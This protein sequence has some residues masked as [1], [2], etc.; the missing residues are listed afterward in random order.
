MKCLNLCLMFLMALGIVKLAN[1]QCQAGETEILFNLVPDNYG[2]ETTWN[3]T[4]PGGGTVYASGGPY[5]NNNTTPINASVCVPTGSQVVFTISDSYGD[6]ICCSSGNGSYT[7]SIS[8]V[9]VASGGSF[10]NSESMTFFAPLLSY[11]IMMGKVQSPFPVVGSDETVEVKSSLTNISSTVITELSISYQAGTEP[12]VTENFTSLNVSPSEKY[13]IKFATLWSPQNT[14]PQGLKVW[15]NSINNGNAD[16]YPSNDTSSIQLDVYQGT[17]IPNIMDDFLNS[18]PVFSTIATSSNQVNKP[19]DLD[20]HTILSRKELWVLNE[21]TESTGGSTVTI[22]NAG[23][24]NQS[25]LWLRDG[26]AWHFMSLPTG[27]AFGTNGNWGTSAGV[28]DANHDGG[29]PFTGPTLWSSDMS[30][31]AQNAGPGTN[32][33]HLDMLHETPY[34]MGI[35]HHKDNAYW[36][37]DGNA[38][39]IVYYD[40]VEDHGPGQHYHGDGIIR[41]YTEVVVAKDGDVPSHLIL[42]KSSGWLYIVDVGNDRV[43]RMNTNTGNVKNPL[44]PTLEQVAEYS[45]M[46][47]VVSETVIDTGL[48]RP[49]GIDLIG[50]RLIVGDYT[51]GDIRF[52][53]ISVNPVAY[54]GKISTGAAG[55]TGLKIGPEGNIWFTNRI[56]HT[57][58]KVVPSVTTS[59]V[60]AASE[61][62][63]AVYP[64]PASTSVNVQIPP[65]V[66]S[67][68]TFMVTDALGR[69]V[70]SSQLNNRTTMSFNTSNWANGLYLIT[71]QSASYK[72]SKVLQI[73]K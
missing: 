32:G 55:L 14:G 10:S 66:G 42:D 31:Y 61:E 45:E 54:L 52:Y 9:T 69:V 41:R 37:F 48:A 18:A 38:N 24:P 25:S 35:A 68:A 6:G 40:F 62:Q 71:V 4:S 58:Q 29:A 1:G 16:M 49:C 59:V 36:L 5:T 3:F 2:S 26:N 70:M 19:T 21:N 43:L 53:D 20:F 51:T 17:V 63:L 12:V 28:Y 7:V 23:M 13:D 44:N 39:N 73:R 60:K 67:D 57:V 15:V 46:E 65:T 33:S 47:N 30:I 50:N 56:N 64:N 22:S 72:E 11:D 8:G 27:L 34:G